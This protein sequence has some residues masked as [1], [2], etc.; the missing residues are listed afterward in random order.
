MCIRDSS[1]IE[2]PGGKKAVEGIGFAAGMERL[3]MARASLGL[4]AQPNAEADVMVLS[5]GDN[6]L[7]GP[8]PAWMSAMSTLQVLSLESCGLTG[9]IP[10]GLGNLTRLYMLNLSG[11]PLIAETMRLHWRQRQWVLLWAVLAR[12]FRWT[13]PMWHCWVTP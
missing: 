12:Q 10:R 4:Q 11:N 6:A 9:P 8:L 5:L 1:R 3:L 2:L 7:S 13:A